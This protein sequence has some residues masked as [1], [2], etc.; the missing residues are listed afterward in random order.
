MGPQSDRLDNAEQH[1]NNQGIDNF[2]GISHLS[3]IYIRISNIEQGIMNVEG[4]DFKILHDSRF[5]VRYS[6]V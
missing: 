6:A 1:S 5:L 3:R 4:N 2:K